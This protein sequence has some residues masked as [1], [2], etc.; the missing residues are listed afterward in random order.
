MA[1]YFTP[2]EAHLARNRL[3]TEGIP[4]FLQGDMLLPD[5]HVAGGEAGVRLFVSEEDA[6]QARDIR[7]SLQKRRPVSP[8]QQKQIEKYLLR[9]LAFAAATW[10]IYFAVTGDMGEAAGV[11][12][13]VPLCAFLIAPLFWRRKK[14]TTGRC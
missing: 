8:E 13:I 1:A 9:I 2:E 6:R 14:V 10:G 12:M 7:S 3:E 11:A 4:C 5:A